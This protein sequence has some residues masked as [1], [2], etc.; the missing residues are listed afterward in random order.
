MDRWQPQAQARQVEFSLYLS[1][2]SPDTRLDRMRLSQ[3]L[4]N[5]LGNAINCTPAGGHIAVRAGLD[6]DEALAISVTDDGIGI[7]PV[8]LP[9]VFHRFYRTDQSRSH[10]IA[11]T[12]LGLAISQAIVEAHGGTIAAASAGVGRGA[13]FTLRLPLRK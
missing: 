1:G 12:G 3:A 8:D 6:S 10:G 2:N 5:V 7:D 13:T 9:H 4:G 11:G